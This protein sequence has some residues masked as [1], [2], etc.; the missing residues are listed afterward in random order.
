[1][2]LCLRANSV[3]AETS[4]LVPAPALGNSQLPA[5]PAPGDQTPSLAFM[6][7]CT[8]VEYTQKDVHKAK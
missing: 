2:A 3:F 6:G 8:R 4:I 5:T 7:T 1:M